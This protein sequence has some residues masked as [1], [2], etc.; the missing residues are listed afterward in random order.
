[1]RLTDLSKTFEQAQMRLT[2]LSDC[3][4]GLPQSDRLYY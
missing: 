1:M 2:D 4:C 3:R